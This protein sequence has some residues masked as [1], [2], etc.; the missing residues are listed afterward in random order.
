MTVSL[1]IKI[2]VVIIAVNLWLEIRQKLK[3]ASPLK[4]KPLTYKVADIEDQIE[5]NLTLELKN[6]HPR[7]EVMVP[8]FS[9]DPILIGDKSYTNLIVK[10]K[11]ITEHPDQ[12]SRSD[13][14]W[15]AYIIKSK[16]KT[17]VNVILNLSSE[18]NLSEINTPHNI[19]LNINWVNY[20]PFGRI[21]RKDGLLININKSKKINYTQESFIEQN[22]SK[23]LPIR[24]HLLGIL[25]EPEKI[26]EDYAGSLIRKGDILTLGETPLAIMQGRYKDPSSIN[27]DFLSR[28]LCRSFHPTSSL[29]TA[30][31]MQVLIDI[32][33]PTRVLLSWLLAAILK[34]FK[35]KGIFYRLAGKQ[36]RLIDD[37][38]G[39][40][41]PYDKTIVLGPIN[42]QEICR[43]ISARLNVDVAIVDV[44]DLGKVK[45]LASSNKKNNSLLLNALVSNPAGNGNEQTPLVLVRPS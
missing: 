10:T 32:I 15:P 4:I 25:D 29:A 28:N 7:M 16:C 1:I 20:G 13:N 42:P 33:G 19:W 26:C 44:N 5:I 14:Y 41:P 39:T 35:I 38:T 31:G 3:P 6:P 36:A 30:C 45:I 11:V 23:V 12:A 27:T 21:L 40:T 9:V 2:L 24:T 34:V 22:N 8:D 18:N 43:K 37:I 17:K